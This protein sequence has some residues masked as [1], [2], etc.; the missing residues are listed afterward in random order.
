MEQKRKLQLE[1]QQSLCR[2]Q[3]TEERLSKIK[4]TSKLLDDTQSND[5]DREED[6]DSENGLEE[7][8]MNRAAMP[9]KNKKSYIEQERLAQSLEQKHQD[10]GC[11]NQE[12]RLQ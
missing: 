7:R 11:Y 4:K 12:C 3:E 9:M 2:L 6:K 10:K 5:T 1:R 8:I